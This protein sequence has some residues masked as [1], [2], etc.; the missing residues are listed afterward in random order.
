VKDQQVQTREKPPTK[1]TT[2]Q[3]EKRKKILDAPRLGNN[4]DEGEKNGG[5]KNSNPE[6]DRG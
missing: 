5:N 4:T 6:K 1:P 3:L 2:Q